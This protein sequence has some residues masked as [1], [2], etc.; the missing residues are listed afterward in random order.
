MIDVR[1]K[2]KEIEV[3]LQSLVSNNKDM[4]L[5]AQKIEGLFEILSKISENT[6]KTPKG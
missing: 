5:I 2:S 4:K 6:Q 1:A 3:Q